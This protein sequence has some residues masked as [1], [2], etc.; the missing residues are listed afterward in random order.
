MPNYARR[1]TRPTQREPLFACDQVKNAA[2]GYVFKIDPF[3]A[4]ERFLILGCEAGTYYTGATKMT[5]RAASTILECAKRD[6]R[7]TIEAIESAASRAIKSDPVIFALALLVGQVKN[8]DVNVQHASVMALHHVNS[9]CRIST[10][11]F[12]FVDQVTQFRGWGSGLRKAV[13]KWYTSKQPRDLLYQVTKYQQ[14]GGWSHRDLLRLSHPVS[15]DLDPVF[16]YIVSGDPHDAKVQTLDNSDYL[17]AIETVNNASRNPKLVARLIREYGLVREHI[18]TR[19]LNSPEVWEALLERMPMTAMIRNLGKMANVGL[20][21]PLSAATKLVC[22]VLRAPEQMRSA[23]VHPFFVLLAQTTYAAGLGVRGQLMWIPNS[24]IVDAL[25]D[26]F[27][28]AFDSV[29]PTGQNFLLGIDVS[30]SMGWRGWNHM[31]SIANTHIKAYQA[32]AV[33]AMT[34]IKTEPWSFAVAFSGKNHGDPSGVCP[35]KLSSKQRLDD[36]LATLKQVPVGPTD[37]SLPMIYAADNKLPVDVFVV[38]TDN[39]TWCGETHPAQALEDYRQKMGRDAKL[40]VCA[41]TATDYSVADPD[42]PGMLDVVGFDAS[43]PTVI[44][45]F[46]KGRISSELVKAT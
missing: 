1:L 4:L 33:M 27:Y 38:Y 24:N 2:G 22:G 36:V 32:A 34:Q 37:C 3:D 39:E 41:M 28:N 15:A 21:T 7:R 12:S 6:P 25:E 40:V 45:R 19:L 43:C 9:V 30:G 46:A 26:A 11:L 5:Q 18:P 8:P 14:R 44:S 29:D 17:A 31:G 42:D 35:V 20:L 10:H 23:H 13:A 16:K